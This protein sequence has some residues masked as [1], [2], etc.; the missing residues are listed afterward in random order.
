MVQPHYELNKMLEKCARCGTGLT[1]KKNNRCAN[2]P[3]CNNEFCDSCFDQLE[4]IFNSKKILGSF[5]DA[6]I[7]S[8]LKEGNLNSAQRTAFKNYWLS[9][10]H[11]ARMVKE[12]DNHWI[13]ED[14]NNKYFISI[15]MSAAGPHHE[16]DE[17]QIEVKGN[18]IELCREEY[19]GRICSK[20]C[21]EKLIHDIVYKKLICINSKTNSWAQ[22]LNEYNCS[23][24]TI[25]PEWLDIW[26]RYMQ[27]HLFDDLIEKIRLFA[28]GTKS[29]RRTA[30]D[31]LLNLL[32]KNGAIFFSTLLRHNDPTIRSD[33]TFI[34]GLYAARFGKDAKFDERTLEVIISLLCDTNPNVCLSA[35]GTIKYLAAQ[36]VWTPILINSGVL[37]ELSKLFSEKDIKTWGSAIEAVGTLAKGKDSQVIIDICFTWLTQ[38]SKDMQKSAATCLFFAANNAPK[39]FIK[40]MVIQK[41]STLISDNNPP[42]TQGM[43]TNALIQIANK[44]GDRILI[45]SG[46]AEQIKINTLKPQFHESTTLL[47]SIL[48]NSLRDYVIRG[49]TGVDDI[50]NFL[51]TAAKEHQ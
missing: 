38:P 12:D 17:N 47:Q 22:K 8:H 11:N 5:S 31:S 51:T 39:A 42:T 34:L 18:G 16:L 40:P 15:R 50:N 2:W 30:R 37:T 26:K 36:E 49:F 35:A 20:K 45:E 1:F 6:S 25:V 44:E 43:I 29:E 24:E 27:E 33:S 9:L 13:I 23:Q 21:G 14:N 32:H 28:K 48:E 4:L 46:L 19:G 7:I 3:D 10:S 41:L